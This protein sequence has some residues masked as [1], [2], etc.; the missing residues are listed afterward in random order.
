MIPDLA[1]AAITLAI[2]Q[3]LQS[4]LNRSGGIGGEVRTE[5]PDKMTDTTSSVV[6]LYLYQ[7]AL[8]PFMLNDDLAQP[9]LR[10]PGKIRAEQIQTYRTPLDLDFLLSFYGDE[11]TLVPQRLMATCI[12]ALYRQPVLT[13][14]AIAAAAS[15]QF[16]DVDTAELP[17]VEAVNITFT[18]FTRDDLYR[19][20]SAFRAPFALSVG[21]QVQVAVVFSTPTVEEV[22]L[23][24]QVDLRVTIPSPPP[25]ASSPA[26]PSP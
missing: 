24:E 6:N 5:R 7:V 3:R 21:Y 20:W 19:L 9:V 25:P 4:A 12:A 17:D 1:I 18:R 22:D 26:K 8:N 10:T 16:P 11:R 13:A 14:K 23:V 15:A 2:K